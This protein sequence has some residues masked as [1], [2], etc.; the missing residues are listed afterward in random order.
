TADEPATPP[1]AIALGIVILVLPV[2]IGALCQDWRLSVAL[3]VLPVIPAFI[4]ASNTLLTPTNTV[5]PP[6]PAKGAQ[7]AAP[8]PTSHFSPA[9]WLDTAH[10]TPLLFSLALFALLGWLGW[11]IGSAF[12]RQP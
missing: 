8:H 5:V 7:P 6:Q 1:I 4:V 2:V 3:A 10:L 9:F 11:V 12:Q